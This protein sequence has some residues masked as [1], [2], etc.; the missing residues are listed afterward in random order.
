[1]YLTFETFSKLWFPLLVSLGIYCLCDGLSRWCQSFDYNLN[2][3]F[4]SFLPS[5]S[6][7]TRTRIQQGGRISSTCHSIKQFT[8]GY[9]FFSNIYC[10]GGRVRTDWQK[11]SS[12]WLFIKS[13]IKNQTSINAFRACQQ[14]IVAGFSAV[15]AGQCL[16]FHLPRREPF[17]KWLRL[18]LNAKMLTR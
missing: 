16:L 4:Q 2:D 18:L 7:L 11:A 12:R 13:K 17:A 15:L 8:F 3:I 1:M 9:F 14:T 6:I 5:G 10:L